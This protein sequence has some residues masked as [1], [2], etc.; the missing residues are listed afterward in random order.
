M[1]RGLIA[2]L[3]RRLDDLRDVLRLDLI[4]DVG[5]VGDHL[6]ELLPNTVTTPQPQLTQDGPDLF[7]H[8]Q[9][10]DPLGVGHL[11]VSRGSFL[12]SS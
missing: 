4:L 2:D 6:G 10:S 5:H 8:S 11:F 9:K 3:L 1:G 7:I 12:T